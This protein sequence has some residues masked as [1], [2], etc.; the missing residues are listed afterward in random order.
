MERTKEE[1]GA[2]DIDHHHI[3]AKWRHLNQIDTCI[4]CSTT[5]NGTERNGTERNGTEQNRTRL[6]QQ[7]NEKPGIKLGCPV[8]LGF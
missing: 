1:D 5:Q 4:Q 7:Y 8:Q 6:M 2:C 3:A